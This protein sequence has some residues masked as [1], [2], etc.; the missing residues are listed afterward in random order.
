R[1]LHEREIR[2]HRGTVVVRVVLRLL[3][4]DHGL[5]VVLVRVGEVVRGAGG[6]RV[7]R[8]RADVRRELPPELAGRALLRGRAED[9]QADGRAGFVLPFGAGDGDG[10]GCGALPSAAADW[11]RASWRW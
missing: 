11:N 2:L 1:R 6:P 9:P 3:P 4:G 5:V 10:F 8:T 7:R